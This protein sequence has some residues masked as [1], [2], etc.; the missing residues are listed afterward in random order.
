[1]AYAYCR[2]LEERPG[3]DTR[4]LGLDGPW[5]VGTPAALIRA[6]VFRQSG[7]FDESLPRLQDFDLWTR[8]LAHRQAVEVPV[9]L[10]RTVREPGISTS[11]H[12]LVDAAARIRS[13]YDDAGFPPHHHAAMHRFIGGA[14]MVRGQRRAAFR[15]LRIATAVHPGV[16]R[17]WV[18]LGAWIFGPAAYR[19]MATLQARLGLQPRLGRRSTS[20][21]RAGSSAAPD[22]SSSHGEG[23]A[24]G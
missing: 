23:R 12:S 22:P 1:A 2:G 10:Y 4:V 3:G 20:P 13:K 18:A 7:G 21:A 15:H 6:E 11:V 17:N 14:L 16:V 8:L 5:M 19:A 24:A 9:V